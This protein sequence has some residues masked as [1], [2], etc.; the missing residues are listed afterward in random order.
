MR[1]GI[2]D[3]GSNSAQLQVVDAAVG[4]PPLPT[5][6]VKEHTRLGESLAPNDAITPDGINRVVDAVNATLAAA[7]RFGV[8]QLYV[9]VTAAIRD[10]TNRAEI[11]DRLERESGVR[12]QFM[13]GVEEAQLTY[14]AARRWYGWRAGRILL[15]DIGGGS[16]EIVLGRDAEPDFAVSLPL[17]A[18]RMSRAFLRRDPPRP[19]QLRALRRHVRDTVRAVA[20]RLRWEGRPD[21]VVATSK[22]F[23][24]LARLTGAPAGR[25]GPFARRSLTAADL[26][27]WT[28]R[29]A[30]RPAARRAQLPGMS[31]TRARHIVAGAVVAGTT[32]NALGVSRAEVCPWALREGV[33]LRALQGMAGEVA[34]GAGRLPLRPVPH[35]GRIDA[36][37]AVRVLNPAT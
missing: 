7:E 18:G 8:D 4:A 12:P 36:G 31:P 1:L 19:R 5:Y 27:A 13:S 9:Y 22:T 10:A 16:M 6:A 3:I 34:D 14:L 37:A 20:D 29:L 30:R 35:M 28:P 17:G 25:K 11:M 23:K 26:D 21:L 2:L 15:L 32:M 33:I 24:Q